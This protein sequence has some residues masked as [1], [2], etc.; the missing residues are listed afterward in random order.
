MAAVEREYAER[1]LTE[2][3][4]E[5]R[6]GFLIQRH[7]DRLAAVRFVGMN[8]MLCG[9]PCQRRTI[10]VRGRCHVCRSCF[11]LFILRAC[12]VTPCHIASS[13]NPNTEHGDRAAI[14]SR[15]WKGC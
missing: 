4:P 14:E 1:M 13:G 2:L 10:S 5:H 9:G 7:A 11:L 8:P 6:H 3:L 15:D 12:V